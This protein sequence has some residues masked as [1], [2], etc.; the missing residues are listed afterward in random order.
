MITEHLLPP[1]G[2][3]VVELVCHEK[4]VLNILQPLCSGS[5]MFF[6]L[7]FFGLLS[8]SSNLFIY[9]SSP[10]QKAAQ[11]HLVHQAV[12]TGDLHL[13]LLRM[14]LLTTTPLETSLD[15]HQMVTVDITV[16]QHRMVM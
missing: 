11:E 16:T 5:Q 4:P 9:V 14:A 8:I 3:M 6:E 12:M 7:F 1:A 10:L 13:M 15:P 2:L